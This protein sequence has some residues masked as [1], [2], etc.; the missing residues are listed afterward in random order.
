M[1]Q[2]HQFAIV[3]RD[4]LPRSS[5]FPLG[6]AAD[7]RYF[8]DFESA[9]MDSITILALPSNLDGF[10]WSSNKLSNL[11]RDEWDFDPPGGRMVWSNG[12]TDVF[13]SRDWRTKSGRHSLRFFYP[14]GEEWSEQRFALGVALKEV[15]FRYWLRV[16]VN[17]VHT[18]G[19]NKFFALWM[20]AYS[21]QGPIVFWQLMPTD[22]T[23]STIR[24]SQVA[25][26]GG[27]DVGGT[28][29][30]AFIRIPE[31]R[32]R[33]MQVVFRIIAATERGSNDGVVEMWRRWEDE[34]DFTKFH[35]KTDADIGPPPNGPDGWKGGYLMGW[36]N[37]VYPE[38]TEF[39]L[40][41]FTVSTTSLLSV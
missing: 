14:A 28:V 29:E 27:P 40:D 25:I 26:G 19:N 13:V 21:G 22:G 4:G 35:E 18:T 11:V 33:W 30:P 6:F 10:T 7:I 20:D 38:N 23:I 24:H 15:W 8:D 31:D 32:G 12:V 3:P 37:G 41:D 36:A 34:P 9:R 16:P 17:Y 2:S 39:L 5:R 1:I